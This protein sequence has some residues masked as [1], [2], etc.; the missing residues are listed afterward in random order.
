MGRCPAQKR[1]IYGTTLYPFILSGPETSDSTVRGNSAGLM[2]VG[3]GGVPV[4]T[5]VFG[6]IVTKTSSNVDQKF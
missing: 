2:W 5:D 4:D 6:D 3:G 1:L